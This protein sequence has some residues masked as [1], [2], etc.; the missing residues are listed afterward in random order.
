MNEPQTPQTPPV[1]DDFRADAAMFTS[2]VLE[3]AAKV[4]IA[5]TVLIA[6]GSAPEHSL[7]RLL[8][9]MTPQVKGKEAVPQFFSVACITRDLVLT[10]ISLNKRFELGL[11]AALDLLA[12]TH[13]MVQQALEAGS[14]EVDAVEPGQEPKRVVRDVVEVGA[15]G[16]AA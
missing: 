16:G 10:L 11:D 1:L 6:A 4:P 13:P 15:Q 12:M 8:P 3:R 9:F 2:Q 5:G 7:T 14:M